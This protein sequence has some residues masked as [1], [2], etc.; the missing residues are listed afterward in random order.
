MTTKQNKPILV[1]DLDETMINSVIG[2][3]KEQIEECFIY[4]KEDDI[5]VFKRNQLIEFL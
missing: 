1:F 3:T 4:M 2:P 5:A